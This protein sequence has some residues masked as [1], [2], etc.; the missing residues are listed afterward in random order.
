MGFWCILISKASARNTVDPYRHCVRQYLEQRVQGKIR[1]LMLLA[2]NPGNHLKTHWKIPPRR[3][4][5]KPS[6]RHAERKMLCGREIEVECLL[7]EALSRSLSKLQQ[8]FQDVLS[9]AVRLR[10][11]SLK[12]SFHS[13]REKLILSRLPLSIVMCCEIVS[14]TPNSALSP[15]TSYWS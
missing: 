15:A 11:H 13:S 1:N 14:I 5:P 4:C 9:S 10:Q 7:R 12:I 8:I 3:R 2:G 6:T